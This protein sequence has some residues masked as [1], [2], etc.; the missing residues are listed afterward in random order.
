MELQILLP[1]KR[2]QK[3]LVRNIGI[4][5][6]SEINFDFPEF[7]KYFFIIHQQLFVILHEGNSVFFFFLFIEQA[8]IE[9]GDLVGRIH[10]DR[11]HRI[12]CHQLHRGMEEA[13]EQ[14]RMP[15]YSKKFI[16]CILQSYAYSEFYEF[17]LIYYCCFYFIFLLLNE[18]LI[19][20]RKEIAYLCISKF[21][22]ISPLVDIVVC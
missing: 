5:V 2:N 4:F 6:E 15:F 19:L 13:T 1:Q 14:N 21:A 22:I 7:Y 17:I 20:G 12:Q 11:F 18:S 3:C 16:F 9:G 8:V 10:F